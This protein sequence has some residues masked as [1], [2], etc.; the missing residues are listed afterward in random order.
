MALRSLD[1]FRVLHEG[2]GKK[3]NKLKKAWGR[4]LE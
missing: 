4:P 2:D 1:I 3:D